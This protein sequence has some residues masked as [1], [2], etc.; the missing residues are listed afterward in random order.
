[1]RFNNFL[2]NEGRGKSIGESKAIENITNNCSHI[3]KYYNNTHKFIFRGIGDAIDDYIFIDPTKGKPRVSKGTKNFYT[4]LMDNLP[5]WK[6]Y[7]KRSQSLICSTSVQYASTYSKFSHIYVVFPYNG[8]NIGVCP[9]GDIW[10]CGKD[11]NFDSLNMYL[12]FIF[13]N[14][15][16]SNG[17]KSWDRLYK[18]LN[19]VTKKIKEYNDEELESFMGGKPKIMI[20]TLHKTKL[21]FLRTVAYIV[22]P[23]INKFDNCTTSNINLKN[24]REIWIGDKPSILVK[25]DTRNYEKFEQFLLNLQK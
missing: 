24:N 5:E 9:T 3:L 18:S 17:D 1:M 19:H 22:N 15:N 14:F 16:I 2:L 12:S 25:Y 7:P 10:S 6:K 8:A 20:S 4:L 11:M 23:T 13:R 21:D